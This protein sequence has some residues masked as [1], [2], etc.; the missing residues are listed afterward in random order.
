MFKEYNEKTFVT[1][2]ASDLQMLCDVI[3]RE[4][5]IIRSVSSLSKIIS[6][7]KKTN[8]FE[9]D[10]SPLEFIFIDDPRHLSHKKVANLRL[11]FTMKLSGNH[12]NIPKYLDSFNSL[13]FN[14]VIYGTNKNNIQSELAY[15]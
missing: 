1:T 14:I 11:L 3:S 2:M 15:F 9:Y 5:K 12:S 7:L 8:K 6:I 4:N 13:E 10:L